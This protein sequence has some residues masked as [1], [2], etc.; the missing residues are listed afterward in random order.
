M[1]AADIDV[2]YDAVFG[3]MIQKIERLVLQC[4][5]RLRVRSRHVDIGRGK[6]YKFDVGNDGRMPAS[7]LIQSM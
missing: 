3:V 4:V 5:T 6:L 7:K 1:M 2:P